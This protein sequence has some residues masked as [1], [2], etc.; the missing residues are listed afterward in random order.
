[1]HKAAIATFTE[2]SISE[3]AELNKKCS[4]K[5]LKILL[6]AYDALNDNVHKNLIVIGSVILQREQIIRKELFQLA[7]YKK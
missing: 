4:L 1:L 2:T 5:V 7:A 6:S 3:S